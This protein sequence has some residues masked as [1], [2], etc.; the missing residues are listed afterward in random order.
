MSPLLRLVALSLAALCPLLSRAQVPA[1]VSNVR[2]T[3]INYHP[4]DLTAAEQTAFPTGEPDDFEFIEV[5]N[6]TAIPVSLTGCTITGGINAITFPT[7]TLAANE[8]V[9]L[10]RDPTRFQFRYGTTPR[11]VFDY[12]GRLSDGGEALVFKTAGGLTIQNFIYDNS[13]AWPGR[14]DGLGASLEAVNLTGNFNDPANWRSSREYGGSPGAVGTG[15]IVNVVINELLGHSDPPFVDFIEL[16][17]TTGLAINIGNWIITD[18]LAGANITKFRIPANTI[19]AANGYRTF[20]SVDFA[21][22]NPTNPLAF[23]EYGERIVV[24][25]AS[26][27]KPLA[28]VDDVRT[29]ATFVNTSEGLI[30]NSAGNRDF[31]ILSSV[32]INTANSAPANGPLV[33]TEIMYNPATNEL[34]FVEIQNTSGLTVPLWDASA[35]A[36]SSNRFWRI[37]D[38][39]EYSFQ[40]GD[41][42]AAGEY[43]VICQT[44]PAVFRAR[45]QVPNHVKIFGP[46]LGSLNNAGEAVRI[47]RPGEYDLVVS[48]NP[49]V[50][51]EKVEYDD[52]APWPTLANGTGRSL[53]RITRGTYGNEPTNWVARNV[54]GSPGGPSQ[55]DFDNDGVPDNW[56][57]AVFQTTSFNDFNSADRDSDGVTDAT[58][59]RVGT[60][61]L[62]ANAPLRVNLSNTLQLSFPSVV[63]TTSAGYYGRSRSYTVQRSTD[64]PS[65]IWNPVSGLLAI[66]ATGSTIQ[67]PYAATNDHEAIRV[68]VNLP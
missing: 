32:T 11:I 34:E 5:R 48:N 43:A 36:N 24:L 3:E 29:S 18:D 33:F 31:D 60:N 14:A 58:E 7:V 28:F 64:L 27:T 19:L 21:A 45:Y 22:F 8:S 2:I 10:A 42:L 67:V 25:E 37:A 35:P 41:Q 62:V 15:P 52:L 23:S 26:A 61:P 38:A 30:I 44:N 4:Y 59:F 63:A 39:V 12:G 9:V 51:V 40:V 49:T 17:N 56:E 16:R 54:L 20:S 46:Y 47:W 65:G 55:V 1:S 6:L 57:Y 13:G 68:Q 66:P 50:Q 53:E